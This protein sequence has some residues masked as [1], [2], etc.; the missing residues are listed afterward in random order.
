M[1]EANSRNR[2]LLRPYHVYNQGARLDG[3]TPRKV[4]IDREDRR[5]FLWL[6]ARHLGRQPATNAR[7]EFFQHLR[8]WV[9][10]HVY[11]IMVTHF[12][13]ILWQRDPR[14]IE[15]LMRRVMTSYARYFNAKYDNDK[16]IFR[17]RYRAKLLDTPEYFRWAVGYI[18]DNHPDGLDYEFSSHRAWV[19]RD[20]RPGWLEPE[21]AISVFGEI[22]DYNAFMQER[23]TKQALDRRL[24]FGRRPAKQAR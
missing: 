24:G 9:T 12:H 20:Q 18:H 21:A 3:K 13:L 1:P 10:L 22:D 4:F 2:R 14:G 6:L 7:G 16:P 19:D 8:N 5:Y 11:C 23:A 17:G 15:E